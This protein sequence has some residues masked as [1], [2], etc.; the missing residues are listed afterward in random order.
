VSKLSC[1][2]A[3]QQA[4]LLWCLHRLC[5]GHCSQLYIQLGRS[6]Q[7]ACYS[8]VQL[9]SAGIIHIVCHH[10]SMLLC[11]KGATQ[12]TLAR[13]SRPRDAPQLTYNLNLPLQVCIF[14]TTEQASVLYLLH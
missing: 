6:E 1:W 12:L 3:D 4:A 2:Q 9:Q 11:R 5:Y 10:T 14:S 8:T 13:L 7:G